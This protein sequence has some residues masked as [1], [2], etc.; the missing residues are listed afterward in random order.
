VTQYVRAPGAAAAEVDG[1]TVVLSP[2]D[3]RYHSLN[4]TAAAIWR[5]LAEPSTVDALVEGLRQEF[6]VEHDEC[7]TGVETCLVELTGLG[8]VAPT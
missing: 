2:S 5:R 4:D 3:L 8:L 1:E 7:R 6:D